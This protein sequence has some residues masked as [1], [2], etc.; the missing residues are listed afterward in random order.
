MG[1]GRTVRRV[2]RSNPP[3]P[4]PFTTAATLPRPSTPFAF[5][6]EK[7]WKNERRGRHGETV[8]LATDEPHRDE[9][10]YLFTSS[11]EVILS[12]RSLS[13]ERTSIEHHASPTPTPCWYPIRVPAREKRDP[14]QEHVSHREQKNLFSRFR[15]KE[16]CIPRWRE[17]PRVP[18]CCVCFMFFNICNLSIKLLKRYRYI[19]V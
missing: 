18:A 7:N 13:Q 9:T 2:S 14:R 1:E 4:P 15:G 19:T 8:R 16:R 17:S 6:R 3:P 5:P 11:L 10:F 12:L